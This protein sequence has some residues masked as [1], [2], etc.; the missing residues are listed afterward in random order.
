MAN[1]NKLRKVVEA[2]GKMLED[3]AWCLNGIRERNACSLV[4]E[5]TVT[6]FTL[7]GFV[8]E[9]SLG[10]KLSRSFCLGWNILDHTLSMSNC[11]ATCLI[12]D[13]HSR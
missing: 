6:G 4:N 1:E 7:P 8:K 5:G 3:A 11:T 10:K 9:K 2:L 12:R 13:R